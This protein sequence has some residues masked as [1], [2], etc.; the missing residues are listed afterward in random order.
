MRVYRRGIGPGVA[1]RLMTT[2]AEPTGG[3]I[4]VRAPLSSMR[5]DVEHL[6][7]E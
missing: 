7:G 2:V 5:K 6:I 4:A 3:H 1:S